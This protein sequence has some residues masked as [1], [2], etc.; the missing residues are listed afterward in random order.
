MLAAATQQLKP[1]PSHCR[2]DL[3][4][5]STA[6]ANPLCYVLA[7]GNQGEVRDVTERYVAN[8]LSAQR[9][10]M[11]EWWKS[12]AAGVA[13]RAGGGYGAAGSSLWG[14]PPTGAVAGFNKASKQS[15]EF[16]DLS[17]PARVKRSSSGD[18][19]DL[20]GETDLTGERGDA[21]AGL[22]AAGSTEKQPGLKLEDVAA[23]GSLRAASAITHASPVSAAAKAA[24]TTQQPRP[25]PHGSSP[26]ISTL[27]ASAATT[28]HTQSHTALP[29]DLHHEQPQQQP[30]SQE[31]QRSQPTP[32]ATS[33]AGSSRPDTNPSMKTALKADDVPSGSAV[34]AGAKKGGRGKTQGVPAALAHPTSGMREMREEAELAQMARAQLHGL[35]TTIDGFKDHPIYVLR[36]HIKKYEVRQG[37]S[38]LDIGLI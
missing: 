4:D 24:C 31:H 8:R 32:V 10:R 13:S 3:V 18:V 34:A 2:P 17:G 6:R 14:K 29:P 28:H 21:H 37:R 1:S 35:P 22:K 16:V 38:R 20:T 15:C 27:H 25:A 11:D 30:N 36:R 9:D 7:C 23:T 12:V 33:H 26:P 19:M 5:T